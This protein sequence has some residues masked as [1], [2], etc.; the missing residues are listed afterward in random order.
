[1]HVFLFWPSHVWVWIIPYDAPV[2]YE[3]ENHFS[4]FR[5]C[6]VSRIHPTIHTRLNLTTSNR[7]K[8]HNK[9]TKVIV[10]IIIIIIEFWLNNNCAQFILFLELMLF[11]LSRVLELC[12]VSR[13]ACSA[14][15]FIVLI[16]K[17]VERKWNSVRFIP[18]LP[19][20]E[21]ICSISSRH[22]APSS[23]LFHLLFSTQMHNFFLLLLLSYYQLY[24]Y[25]WSWAYC[26]IH[27]THNKY[28]A[29]WCSFEW[30]HEYC[31]ESIWFLGCIEMD[32]IINTSQWMNAKQYKQ[33]KVL[34]E[35]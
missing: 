19:T 28:T 15:F 17:L 11:L 20:F 16:L 3:W 34:C 13:N 27:Q 30:I 33:K 4:F 8:K 2:A 23:H 26:K 32:E 24:V 10:N 25:N 5:H 29:C 22:R 7:R 9:P 31:F 18:P 12:V 6:Y 21:P 1:M 35:W 14:F